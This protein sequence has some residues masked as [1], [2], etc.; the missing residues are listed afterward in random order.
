M[1]NPNGFGS[2]IK[3]GGKRRRPYAAVVTVGFDDNGKQQ[4][5]FIGYSDNYKGAM[6]ILIEYSDNPHLYLNNLTLK[7]VY[8]K[9]SYIHY[10]KIE[11]SSIRSYKVA[12]NKCKGIMNMKIKDIRLPD[13]QSIADSCGELNAAKKQFKMLLNQ[14]FKYAMKNEYI[15]K[16]YS[17]YIDVGK[18]ETKIVRMPFS[19]KEIKTLWQN[20]DKI[21]G[22]DT[23]LI[24][25]YTGFRIGEL[26]DLKCSNINLTENY[27]VG[28]KKTAAGKDR[29]VPIHHKIKQL[30][31]N[32][33][34]DRSGDRFF[35][36]TIKLKQMQYDNYRMCIFEPIM[37]QL[38]MKH[39]IHDTRHTFATL[40]SNVDVNPASIKKLVGHRHYLTTEKIYTHKSIEELR[41]AIEKI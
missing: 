41:K 36:E 27:I 35:I 13:L 38:N 1:K 32:R 4:R 11:D 21:K 40:L 22:I 16:D 19:N 5:K 28:G 10:E 37:N 12:W 2:V 29:V 3:L 34:S 30:I 39:R 25:I 14:V 26:L 31:E 7:Q 33:I 9:W 20:A 18:S 15:L 8:D 17:Q 23:I 6:Q 24:L